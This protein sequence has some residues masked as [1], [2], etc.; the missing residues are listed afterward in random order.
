MKFHLL[1]SRKYKI[2]TTLMVNRIRHLLLRDDYVKEPD[3]PF[4]KRT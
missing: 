2:T 1:H 3:V 4:L